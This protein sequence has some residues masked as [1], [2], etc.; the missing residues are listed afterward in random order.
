VI[1]RV[2]KKHGQ[3]DI[4]VDLFDMGT[5]QNAFGVFSH[6]RETVDT[7]LGQGFQ[8]TEGSVLFW[9][10]RYF[11]SILAHPETVES[12]KAVFKL[13]KEIETSIAQEGPLPEIL[14]YLPQKSLAEES[15][16]YFHHHVWLN[17]YYFVAHENILHINE[18]T[19]AILAKYGEKG[20][21]AILLLVKYPQVNDAKLAYDDFLKYYLPELSEEQIVQIEDSTWTTGLVVGNFLVIVFNAPTKDHADLLVEAVR[22]NLTTR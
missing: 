21:R 20:K 6:T 22:K 10:N 12:K 4:I 8:Q 2:Y 19:D 15:I 1:N 11:I 9:K 18:K 7:T 17:S 5:S 13:A 16:R 14:N 3:P